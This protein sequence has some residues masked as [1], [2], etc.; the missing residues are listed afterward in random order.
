MHWGKMVF[1]TPQQISSYF[2]RRAA[3]IRQQLPSDADI[4]ASEEDNF[5]QAR[6]TLMAITLQHPITFDQHD[7]CAMA[8]DGS[9]ERLSMLQ[10][11]C[12]KVELEVLPKLIRRKRIYLDLFEKAVANCACHE[13]N[14]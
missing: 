13:L 2:S 4:R 8:K 10:N 12:Q 3:K 7:I 14:G 1:L 6:E 5:A 9:L 11:I